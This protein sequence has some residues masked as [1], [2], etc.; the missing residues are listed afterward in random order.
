MKPT[1]VKVLNEINCQGIDNSLW[2]IVDHYT[3]SAYYDGIEE[4]ALYLRPHIYVW[5]D[6]ETEHLQV[7]ADTIIRWDEFEV[8]IFEFDIEE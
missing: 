3:T 5:G 1:I 4:N 2:G 7:M 8:F 6:K